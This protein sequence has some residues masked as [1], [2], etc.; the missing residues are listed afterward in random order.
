MW[1]TLSAS[2]R[3]FSAKPLCTHN[4]VVGINHDRFVFSSVHQFI[5]MLMTIWL[6]HRNPHET[7]KK[8]MFG[9]IGPAKGENHFVAKSSRFVLSFLFRI[10]VSSGY[11]CG[12]I[13]RDDLDLR[14]RQWQQQQPVELIIELVQRCSIRGVH[15]HHEFV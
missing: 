3:Q 9:P 15:T 1:Y 13:A 4:F 8:K 6:V 5:K 11:F 12:A 14:K 2:G 10:S 7:I